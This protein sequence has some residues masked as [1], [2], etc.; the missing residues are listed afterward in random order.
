LTA[1]VPSLQLLRERGRYGPFEAH[2]AATLARLAEEDDPLVLLGAAEAG[3][4]IVHGHVC[5]E[6]GKLAG[7]AVVDSQG[8]PLDDMT[9]PD[10]DDWIKRLRRSPLV[11]D[12][13]AQTPL[14]L[15]AGGR[16]YLDRY[17]RYETRLA[18]A[19]QARTQRTR[20]TIDETVLESGFDRLFKKRPNEPK[21]TRLQRLAALV[22]VE[23]SFCAISGGPGTGKTSTVVNILAL[24]QEQARATGK[25]FPLRI[26]LLAPTG[27]A[28]ARLSESILQGCQALAVDPEIRA[29]IP[30][31]ASTIHRGLGFLPFS[32]THFRHHADNPLPVDAVV[33]DEA[34]MVD[35]ALMTK[36]FEAT[37]PNARIILLGDRDQLAS[38]EA[39]AI[40]GDICFTGGHRPGYSRALRKRAR[41]FARVTFK[42]TDPPSGESGIWDCVVHL[43]HSFRFGENSEIALL[44]RA[45]NAGD[46]SRALDILTGAER[47]QLEF[48]V[49][50]EIDL[51]RPDRSGAAAFAAEQALNGY[52]GYLAAREPEQ[53][54]ERL[55]QFRILC[56]HRTGPFGAERINARIEQ[57]L[58]K[59]G[60]LR[61]EEGAYHLRPILIVKNDHQRRLFNGDVGVIMEAP[62]GG[63][64]AYFYAPD[65]DGLRDF[66]PGQLPP[67]QTVFAMTVHKSQ[68]SEFDRV[69]LVLPGEVSRVLTRELLYT[70]IT[71][72]RQGVTIL[73]DPDVIAAAVER[74]VDRASGL[75]GALWG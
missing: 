26:A 62:S 48:F 54:L 56:A 36:L 25:R 39:G 23:R 35:L 9:W 11:G 38:V 10:L 3:R 42:K 19:I 72:A 1:P 49:T 5:V 28:A 33:V 55:R 58:A 68:G 65:G 32:P 51:V 7:A 52:R 64:R 75:R 14:V 63:L 24:L 20:G 67:H 15:D 4:S 13:S 71:R 22:A 47:D 45:I 31:E 46:T 34:S 53:A 40:F 70:G 17:H 2:F 41:R 66:S 59:T 69:A 6:L 29:S 43:T 44:S 12:G 8:V 73:G 50:K 16:L 60:A 27:K 57:A 61:V 18:H 21:E 30:T 74:R 37:P